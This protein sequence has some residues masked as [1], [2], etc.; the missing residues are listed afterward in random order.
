M[1]GRSRLRDECV[2]EFTGTFIFLALGMGC[3]AGLKLTGAVYGQWEISVIWGIGVALGAYVAGGVSG[4]HLNPSVTLTLA[5]FGNFPK[6]KIIPFII[7]QFLG[8]VVAAAIVYG[9]YQN[10]FTEKTLA[11]ASI[12]TTFP[13]PHITIAQAFMTELFITALLIA[14]ILGLSDDGNGLPRGA[15]APFLVGLLVA[16]IGGA[17]GPLTGFAMN[18][19]RDFGPRLF[20]YFTGWGGAVMTGNREVPYFLVPLIAPIIGGIIG[21]FFYTFFIGKPLARLNSEELSA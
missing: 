4:A 1:L 6:R 15:L 17:F 13:N 11:N 21:G 10:L 2:A 20:A 16:V 19:A 7:A 5:I 9:L 12:F 14:V 18:G 8:A 3:V